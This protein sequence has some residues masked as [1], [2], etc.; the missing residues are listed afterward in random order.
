MSQKPTIP[1]QY[2][3]DPCGATPRIAIVT[4][5]PSFLYMLF[6]TREPT[7]RKIYKDIRGE[8]VECGFEWYLPS[9]ICIPQSNPLAST[10]HQFAL[11]TMD[12]GTCIWYSISTSCNRANATSFWPPVQYCYEPCPPGGGFCLIQ[13]V[14]TLLAGGSYTFGFRDVA[15]GN[16]A[17]KVND[18][19]LRTFSTGG[20]NLRGKVVCRADPFGPADW[21]GHPVFKING[22]TILAAGPD[23]T[24]LRGEFITLQLET[25]FNGGN[26]DLLTFGCERT[27]ASGI[28]QTTVA[29]NVESYFSITPL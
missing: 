10:L 28:L 27:S 11:P 24:S 19:T 23:Q 22:A 7:K 26:F 4:Q 17:V 9:P 2:L 1:S 16:P 12:L 14:P 5:E 25:S 13:R 29:E 8:P 20:Y 15:A 21:T 3:P 18:L 6:S